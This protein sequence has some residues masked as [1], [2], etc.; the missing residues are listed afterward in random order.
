MQIVDNAQSVAMWLC[1]KTRKRSESSPTHVQDDKKLI[2]T[3]IG[4]IHRPFF[5]ELDEQY[6]TWSLRRM[7]SSV[8]AEESANDIYKGSN[9]G[10]GEASSVTLQDE[11][12]RKPCRWDDLEASV[13][14]DWSLGS[15]SRLEKKKQALCDK[16]DVLHNEFPYTGEPLHHRPGL[17][18]LKCRSSSGH[19]SGNRC[20]NAS[21]AVEDDGEERWMDTGFENEEIEDR[22][23]EITGIR[24]PSNSYAEEF[25]SRSPGS[26]GARLTGR[27]VA[28]V[29]THYVRQGKLGEKENNNVSSAR[30]ALDLSSFSNCNFVDVDGADG[31]ANTDYESRKPFPQYQD[32]MHDEAQK[33]QALYQTKC[34]LD[35]RL[36]WMKMTGL[37]NP[38]KEVAL[39]L[40]AERAEAKQKAF[41]DKA[42][43]S[44][45][46]DGTPQYYPLPFLNRDDE[47]PA[48]GREK[49][50][51]ERGQ[52]M[53]LVSRLRNTIRQE[54]KKTDFELKEA[55]PESAGPLLDPIRYHVERRRDR[56][57]VMLKNHLEEFLTW[58]TG[59]ML[60]N[61]LSEAAIT[62]NHVSMKTTKSTM[63]V[64]YS[65]VSNHDKQRVQKS[66]DVA[67]P[68]LRH[69]LAQKLE[70]GYTPPIKFILY[71]GRELMS[72][73]R[74]F[75]LVKEMDTD[76][77]A[78]TAKENW[79]KGME[80][81]G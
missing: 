39:Q 59:S 38:E 55:M 65:V 54:K 76:R 77:V 67:A 66:L 44:G 6:T 48:I 58:N 17:A 20:S 24:R 8:N 26:N 3:N 18:D 51:I 62:I 56:I 72:K 52:E 37:P 71:A 32:L 5:H 16:S 14:R 47:T 79:M 49:R 4:T 10:S 28:D 64:Y 22:M 21:G 81:I 43:A 78:R 73:K 63:H 13:R 40:K 15:R 25:S 60:C 41:E 46:A 35:R 45:A 7:V 27:K 80:G 61:V 50:L 57:G 19:R 23:A 12:S 31:T 70:L 68:K 34:D 29:E 11:L 69:R 75:G 33:L 1:R 9:S 74:L 36:R 30:E 42:K 2:T 53:E